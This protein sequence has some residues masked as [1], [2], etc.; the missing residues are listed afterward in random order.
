MNVAGYE[1][2]YN[3]SIRVL[4]RAS[5]P[6]EMRFASPLGLVM[7]KLIAWNDN[8]VLRK[9]DA[10][11]ILYIMSSYLDL[12]NR[13]RLVEEHED[14]LDEGEFDE[15]KIGARLLGRD[16]SLLVQKNTKHQ[17]KEI[18]KKETKKE[19]ELQLI[20]D[21]GVGSTRET[22]TELRLIALNQLLFGL[23]E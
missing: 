18:L 3:C 7:L 2:A 13:V 16:L 5:P 22:S 8:P 10:E 23:V 19:G 12:D 6:L 15:V 11:D 1:D 20:R 9:K 14:L 4:L 21:M 17:I